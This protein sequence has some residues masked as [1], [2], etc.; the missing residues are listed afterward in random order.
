V[1]IQETDPGLKEQLRPEM[2][3]ASSLHADLNDHVS[4]AFILDPAAVDLGQEFAELLAEP[5]NPAHIERF[6]ALLKG[7]HEGLLL[8]QIHSALRERPEEDVAGAYIDILGLAGTPEAQL[9]LLQEVL[10]TES[11]NLLLQERAL[12]HL[13]Q[14]TAPEPAAPI[15]PPR[16]GHKQRWRLVR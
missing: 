16:C 12:T 13:V 9:L 8:P 7:D 15:Q 5:T 14:V 3:E 10:F 6:V 1:T 11:F 4:N 2:Y